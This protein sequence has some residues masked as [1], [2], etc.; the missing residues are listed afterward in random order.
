MLPTY[1]ARFIHFSTFLSNR[2]CSQIW[3]SPLLDDDE[4]TH[5]PDNFDGKKT[6]ICVLEKGGPLG[7]SSTWQVTTS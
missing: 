1:I 6:L 4:L 2:I 7:P 5:L 3:L